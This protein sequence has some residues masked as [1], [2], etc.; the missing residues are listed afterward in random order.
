MSHHGPPWS[1]MS[2]LGPPWNEP[3]ARQK[4][5]DSKLGRDNST[6]TAAA[7]D[8]QLV[9]VGSEKRRE[10]S[11][12]FLPSI[13]LRQA[14]PRHVSPASDGDFFIQRTKVMLGRRRSC[15]TPTK[16]SNQPHP[17]SPRPPRRS[18]RFARVHSFLAR[19]DDRKAAGRRI[20][21]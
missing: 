8:P 12:K 3:T 10:A 21:K 11:I 17:A 19:S 14:T 18:L 16:S 20:V 9:E 5:C 2:C 15:N 13:K 4:H 1:S 7:G 6:A